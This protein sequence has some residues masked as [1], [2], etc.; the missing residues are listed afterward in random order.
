[1]N[2]VA[3]MSIVGAAIVAATLGYSM[4]I[5]VKSPL[6]TNQYISQPQPVQFS[7]E[8]H[9]TGL[10]IDCRYCH[11]SVENSSF[12]NIPP[13]STCMNCHSQIWYQ[14]PILEPVRA[15]WRSGKPLEWNRVHNLADFVYFNHSIHV[16]KGIGCVSCHGRVDKM[17]LIHK[18]EPMTMEWCLTCHR[19]PEKFIRPKDQVVNFT[20]EAPDPNEPAGGKGQHG[21]GPVTR[22]MKG[23]EKAVQMEANQVA[24][25]KKLLAEYKIPSTRHLTSCSTCHR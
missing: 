11:T 3:K 9:Y 5:L 6:V 4:W 2:S 12:A 1:M 22:E 18:A 25:G 19:N 17:Q 14:S 20:W 7:H 10:G 13:T 8:H 21:E 23:G 24:L 16:N 15:S